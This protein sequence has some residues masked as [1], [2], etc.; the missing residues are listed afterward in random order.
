M[1]SLFQFSIKRGQLERF[2]THCDDR[3]LFVCFL[4]TKLSLKTLKGVLNELC[5]FTEWWIREVMRKC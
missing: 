4:K 5:L 2:G 3:L 1:T